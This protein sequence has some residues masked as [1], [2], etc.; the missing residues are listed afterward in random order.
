M[1]YPMN[2]TKKGEWLSRTQSRHAHQTLVPLAANSAWSQAL[3]PTH[4]A[5]MMQKEAFEHLPAPT[6]PDVWFVYR[7]N[8]AISFWDTKAVSEAMTKF[9]FIVCFAYTPDET[10]DMADILLPECTDLEGLQLIRI[11]GSKYIEQFWDH[12]GFALRDPASAPLGEARDFTWIATELAKRT[13][14]LAEYNSAINNGAAG[15]QL[16]GEGFDFSLDTGKAHGVEEIWDASCRAASAELTGGAES[17][18]LEYFREHGFRVRPFAQEQWY[19]D[20]AM[21]AQGLRYEMPYQERLLRIG[22][23]LGAR[24]HET[25]ISWWDRQLREYEAMPSWQDLQRHWETALAEGFGVKIADYPFWLLTA[26]SMQYSWGGNA[27]LQM[28]HEVAGNIAGHGGVVMNPTAA[29]ELSL[30]EGD[31][32]EVASPLGATRGAVVLRHGIRP[33]TLLMIGQFDHWTTPFAK[34]LK[35]P[36]M[37]ALTP[38]MLELT[39][40]T[41]SGAD[42]V[43][44]SV[45]RIGGPA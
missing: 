44:V 15:V 21:E 18:G 37:N 28:I 34:D 26:R 13:G 32:I 41:G 24:L 22:Q 25:G 38:M 31:Q 9:P 4:L 33:D 17:Q 20:P 8:P 30:S 6:Q 11:G 1:H 43:K 16:S 35:V 14:L 40:A 10:N 12:T 42:L 36:S 45:R 23:E 39:D 7:T 19:L 3:G 5:W 29:A 2:P 27:N